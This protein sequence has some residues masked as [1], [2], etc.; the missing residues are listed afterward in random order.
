MLLL[1]VV[2]ATE[3]NMPWGQRL[4]AP[5]GIVLFASAVALAVAGMSSAV[6]L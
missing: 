5:L 1:A 3:K 6:T 2:M 4:S